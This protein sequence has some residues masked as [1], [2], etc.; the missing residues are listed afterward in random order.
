VY[1]THSKIFSSSSAKRKRILQQNQP[2]TYLQIL[3]KHIKSRIINI[4]S[5]YPIKA[6]PNQNFQMAHESQKSFQGRALGTI[7][8]PPDFAYGIKTRPSG[9]VSPFHSHLKSGAPKHNIFLLEHW[10]L[11]KQFNVD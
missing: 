2:K 8:R 4:L 1:P 6:P 5:A 3:L 10:T 9:N 11:F 7:P